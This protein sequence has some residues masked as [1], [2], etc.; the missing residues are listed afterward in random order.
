MDVGRYEMGPLLGRGGMARV[1]RARDTRLGR[2]V[3]VKML[4]PALAHDPVA[5]RRFLAEARAAGGLNHP[6]V[7]TVHDHDEAEVDG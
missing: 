4:D 2:E 1:Y 5:R 6:G 7:V 3:A